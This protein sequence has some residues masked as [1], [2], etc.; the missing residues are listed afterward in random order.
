MSE[1][2][3]DNTAGHEEA[4]ISQKVTADFRQGLWA[5]QEDSLQACRRIL[6]GSYRGLSTSP[7]GGL[8]HSL[9]GKQEAA[10]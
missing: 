6:Y 9:Q 1:V 10:R 2:K 7:T 5:L 8:R 4:R 3:V